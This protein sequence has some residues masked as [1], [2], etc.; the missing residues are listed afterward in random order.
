M[1]LHPS[2]N[3]G[4]FTDFITSRQHELATLRWY[5]GTTVR[6]Y[7]GTQVLPGNPVY[8]IRFFFSQ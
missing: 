6:Q 8:N 7:E 4:L 5:V 1:F 3:R 2:N